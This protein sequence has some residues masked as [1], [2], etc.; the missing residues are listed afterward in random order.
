MAILFIITVVVGFYLIT[1]HLQQ[2]LEAPKECKPHKWVLRFE[3][4]D[5]RGYLICSECKKIP[6]E[7]T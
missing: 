5:K 3:T 1:N 4:N 7:E 2:A 6:G